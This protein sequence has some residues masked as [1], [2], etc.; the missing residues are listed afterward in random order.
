MIRAEDLYQKLE[1][2]KTAIQVNSSSDGTCQFDVLAVKVCLNV[3]L[4]CVNENRDE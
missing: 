1:E 4:N 3:A 2:I